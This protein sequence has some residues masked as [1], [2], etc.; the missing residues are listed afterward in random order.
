VSEAYIA[1]QAPTFTIAGGQR[2]SAFNSVR[3]LIAKKR[4]CT[5]P[6]SHKTRSC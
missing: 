4:R 5:V 3:L 1:S 6:I 2:D